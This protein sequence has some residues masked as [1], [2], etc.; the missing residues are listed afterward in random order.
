MNV[1]KGLRN[2][3]MLSL[4][5]GVLIS[6]YMVSAEEY[7]GDVTDTGKHI[8][9]NGV[10]N[11]LTTPTTS[12]GGTGIYNFVYG[13]FNTIKNTKFS[14]IMGN[15]NVVNN[16]NANQTLTY[17]TILGSNNG[18]ATKG[19]YGS[20][21]SILGTNNISKGTDV[22]V[23][24]SDN[25]K[26]IDRD[27]NDR[28]VQ[29]NDIVVMG[30][31]NSVWANDTVV[32]GSDIISTQGN[33]VVL[34][35]DSRD[36]Q[37][38]IVK[39]ATVKGIT[40]GDFAGVATLDKYNEV[41]N[42]VVSVGDVGNERQVINVAS[43][44]VSA[45]STDAINGSQLYATN[46]VIGNVA[47]SVKNLFGGNTVVNE[48]GTITNNDIGGTG[49]ST[50]DDAIKAVNDG[51]QGNADAINDLREETEKAIQGNTDL[52]NKNTS[53]IADNKAAIE[54]N[55]ANIA[56][57]RNNIASLQQQTNSL[58]N[59]MNKVGAGAAALA[60][61]HPLDFNADDKWNFAVGYGNYKDA[62]AMAVGA[63][64]RPNEDTMLSVAGS[65]GNGEN[66][67]NA[68][69]SFKIGQSNGVTNSKV[70]LAKDVEELKRIVKAQ[71]AEIAQLR[72][73]QVAGAA[74]A[75]NETVNRNF[76]DLPTDHWAYSYV[77]SLAAQGL[78]EGYPDGEYKGDR[79]MTRYEFAA[80]VYR[81]L[82]NGAKIDTNMARAIEEFN[83]EITRLE[84]L[85]HSRIDRVAG[86]DNDR[87]KIERLRANNKD[88]KEAGIYRDVYG[89]KIQK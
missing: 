57:N 49:T 61:L 80:V 68:G 30:A 38:T 54:T 51:N 3:V 75:S 47:E 74:L 67:V 29:G 44:E 82:Q 14:N 79:Q 10:K 41:K 8:I 4:A 58:D 21:I 78:V 72:Q 87:H 59:R 52:I 69:L 20:R 26:G 73:G 9:S 15:N 16:E 46:V 85:D 6:P 32:I 11:T 22:V 1:K 62:N 89:A 27:K 23:I 36:R 88:D 83:P 71:S 56:E 28:I 42:G 34:G 39:N 76:T 12:T 19:I 25:G 77:K 17:V 48:D 35:A 50:I 37:A 18:D 66:M 63:F 84:N 33:S 64:Y 45:T 13:D 2:L 40:Y 86:E 81:A 65:M 70:A 53:D 31:R 5:S 7:T 60:A 43:G 24:G 55:A